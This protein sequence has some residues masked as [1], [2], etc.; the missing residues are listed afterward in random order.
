MNSL[1]GRYKIEAF[2][3]GQ[4]PR[5]L[6]DWF[7]NLITDYGLDAIA[8]IESGIANNCF[9]G[10]GNTPPA[11]TDIN[12][13]GGIASTQ[14]K[15]SETSGKNLTE[16]Y[17][18]QR[19]VWEFAAGT[20]TGNLSEVGVG[21][22]SNTLFSRALIKDAQGNPTSIA[23]L[24]QE[25]L[26]VTWELRL[27]WPQPPV[28]GTVN[29]PGSGTHDFTLQ[30][31]N[32]D[33]AQQWRIEASYLCDLSHLYNYVQLYSGGVSQGNAP[34]TI[35]HAPYAKGLFQ[36]PAEILLPV[37]QGN[38]SAGI[39]A[40]VFFAGSAAAANPYRL[41]FDPPILKTANDV[42]RLHITLSWG[43]S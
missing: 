33:A 22:T 27:Y 42:L 40:V 36:K 24:P 17:S 30:A 16:G 23:V 41:E 20:A 10:S 8:T 19:R 25:V 5:L 18:W 43:R 26:Q 9:V 4:P 38:Y 13:A 21:R 39:D 15:I 32:Q 35:T 28:T 6:A 29:I 1:H 3:P 11:V 2:Q 37:G 7:S 14:N 34:A 31:V 12:L